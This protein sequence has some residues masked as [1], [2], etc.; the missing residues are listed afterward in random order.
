MT[1]PRRRP[2]MKIR[3]L[4]ALLACPLLLAGLPAR[5]EEEDMS[6][7]GFDNMR[8]EQE[9]KL[10]VPLEIADEVLAFIKSRYFDDKARIAELD[11]HL[12]SS[13]DTEDFTDVYYDTPSLQMLAR[14]SG[15]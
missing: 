4:A 7:A 10:F 12:T 5:A 9:E 6:A 15:V 11:P 3:R 2:P 14:Q 8:I 1:C 13:W